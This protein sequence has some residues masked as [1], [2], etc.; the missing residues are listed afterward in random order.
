MCTKCTVKTCKLKLLIEVCFQSP[1]STLENHA[2]LM[3]TL[4]RTVNGVWSDRVM[5][6]GDF[7]FREINYNDITGQCWNGLGSM[8]ILQE[9]TNDTSGKT[10]SVLDYGIS[11]QMK[12][13][14]WAIWDTKH[15]W[16]T[17][18]TL[19]WC[20]LYYWCCGNGRALWWQDVS[21]RHYSRA[22]YDTGTLG[23]L[24]FTEQKRY[25]TVSSN[26]NIYQLKSPET[27]N[28]HTKYVLCLFIPIN[29]NRTE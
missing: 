26:N 13:C 27:D 5:I 9:I 25:K 17:A 21:N 19:V 12:K 11:L 23:K 22:D 20:V 7:S 10:A 6:V 2:K 18:T 28:L 15:L 1:A 4:D 16:E 29:K 14:S 8:Q 3:K 24:I